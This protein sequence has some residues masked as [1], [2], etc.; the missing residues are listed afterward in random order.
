[1]KIETA[2]KI[3]IGLAIG[4]FVLYAAFELVRWRGG[5]GPAAVGRAAGGVAAAFIFAVYLRSFVKRSA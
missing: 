4:L 3:L 5:G 2:H 1:M